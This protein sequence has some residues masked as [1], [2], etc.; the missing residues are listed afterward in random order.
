MAEHV[1]LGCILLMEESGGTKGFCRRSP[2]WSGLT[3]QVEN[4]LPQFWGPAELQ[5]LKHLAVLVSAAAHTICFGSISK[6][7][8][9][10]T[11][12]QHA[13]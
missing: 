10:L 8:I 2:L 7:N 5:P 11:A 9:I 13:R 1:G 6:R 12:L 3:V 4:C